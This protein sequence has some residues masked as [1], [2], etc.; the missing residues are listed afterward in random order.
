QV[1]YGLAGLLIVREPF[2]QASG[3]PGGD[4]DL[5][6][7]IQDRRV[8]RD[9]SFAYANVG[10]AETLGN[11]T[12][13]DVRAFYERVYSP[14]TASVVTV[15]DIP[16]D[17]LVD[18]LSLLT[19]WSGD[20]RP[21]A[22]V[23]PLPELEAGTLYVIDKPDAAQSEIR[24]G[25]RAMPY[26]AL[27]EFH[28]AQLMNFALGGAFNSRINLNLRED[29]GFTYGARSGFGGDD[30]F[31]TFRASAGVRTDATAAAIV[32][33][34]NEIERYGEHG[35]SQEE[36]EFTKQAI[37]Q[38]DALR[39]ETPLQ[40]LGLLSNIVTFDLPDDFTERQGEILADIGKPEIDRL[41]KEHLKFDDMILVVVGDTDAILPELE[42]LAYP[43]VQLD[44]EGN[45]L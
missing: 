18:S 31:G 36:L 26:D 25:M 17:E 11:I 42:S 7:V 19:E 44:A 3:L 33:F 23:Q 27:G 40:K 24:I 32:E 41:A 9:N 21:K 13:D 8:A 30:R 22:R 2:E 35:I 4:F 34:V 37:G 29:K 39:Y 12:L 6:L 43:I 14:V 38:R 10:L 1:Y 20:E 5:P 45:P 15:S 28:R 16:R